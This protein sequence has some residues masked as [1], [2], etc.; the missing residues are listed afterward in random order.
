MDNIE[1]IRLVK[2]RR[3]GLYNG[4]NIWANLL[5]GN[6]AVVLKETEYY[7]SLHLRPNHADWIAFEQV[8]RYLCYGVLEE[9]DSI[10][11]VIDAGA[12]I[13]L[14]S[15]YF[16]KRLDAPQI[17]ALE[18]ETGN[19]KQA[20]LNTNGLQNVEI[21]NGALWFKSGKV[22]IANPDEGALGFQVKE[23]NSN[24]GAVTAYTFQEILH[25]KGWDTVDLLKIDIEG[26]EKELLDSTLHENWLMKVRILIIELHDR[27]RPGCSLSFFR[28]ISRLTNIRLTVSGENLVV[29]NL[30]L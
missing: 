9:I 22:Q 25:M 11:T 15:V 12:N 1:L 28:A 3:I 14:S 2:N 5:Q 30:D 13:G 19:F 21:L 23:Y 10:R 16:S 27:I 24:D 7:N 8:F 4:I 29:V 17:I 6:K 26:A 18:P 20:L